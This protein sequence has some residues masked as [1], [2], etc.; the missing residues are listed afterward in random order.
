VVVHGVDGS[1]QAWDRMDVPLV[2]RA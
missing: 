1:E 2:G